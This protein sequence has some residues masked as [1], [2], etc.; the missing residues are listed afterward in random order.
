ML[1]RQINIKI[2][3]HVGIFCEFLTFSRQK[4]IFT[5]ESRFHAKKTFSHQKKKYFGELS[6][7]IEIPCDSCLEEDSWDP[8]EKTA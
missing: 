2:F 7:N 5:H 6:S 1:S 3:S 8:K 4:N